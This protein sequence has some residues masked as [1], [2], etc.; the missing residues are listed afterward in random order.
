MTRAFPVYIDALH[1]RVTTENEHPIAVEQVLTF[2]ATEILW[3][4]GA[5]SPTVRAVMDVA[6]IVPV[7]SGDCNV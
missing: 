7:T 2:G 4:G 1:Y 3:T 5:M 6:G